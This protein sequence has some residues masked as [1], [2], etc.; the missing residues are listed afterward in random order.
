MIKVLK[1]ALL[2]IGYFIILQ[3]VLKLAVEL[4]EAQEGVTNVTTEH[5][6]EEKD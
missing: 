3:K 4:L 6:E 2:Y 5:K 1:T